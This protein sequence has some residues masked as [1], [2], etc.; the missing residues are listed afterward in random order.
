MGRGR[1]TTGMVACSLIATIYSY[2]VS[3][4]LDGSDDSAPSTPGGPHGFVIREDG[5]EEEAY[6]QGP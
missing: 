5:S 1:T 3:E 2:D 4:G 6:L